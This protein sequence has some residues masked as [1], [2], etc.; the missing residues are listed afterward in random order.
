MYRRIAARRGKSVAGVAV[1]RTILEICYYMIRDNT[2]YSDLG[3]GYLTERNRIDI[4][5]RSVKRL[6][7]LGFSVTIEEVLAKGIA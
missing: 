6:Q 3:A 1:A 4:M 2:P 7:S 5:K